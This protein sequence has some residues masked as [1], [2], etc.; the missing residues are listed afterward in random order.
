MPV[1]AP[2]EIM[3]AGPW[4]VICQPKSW[5]KNRWVLPESR[6]PISKCTTGLG[7]VILLALYLCLTAALIS[8]GL[9]RPQP[10]SVPDL[11]GFVLVAYSLVE[12]RGQLAGTLAVLAGQQIVFLLQ[13]VVLVGDIQ[14]GQHR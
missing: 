8:P 9:R 3:A 2:V 13:D 7:F 12:G 14:R 10:V 6:Q 4:A 1:A 5:E 11:A